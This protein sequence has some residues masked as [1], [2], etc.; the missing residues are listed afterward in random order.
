MKRTVSILFLLL[1]LILPTTA[2][3][4]KGNETFDSFNR[5]KRSLQHQ[6]YH[7]HR[8]TFYCGCPFD[9]SKKL[10]TSPHYTPKRVNSRSKRI[11]W[12]HVV[13]AYDFGR[14]FS[15]WRD[16]HPECV[17]SKGK[18]FKGRNCA[19]KMAIPFRYMEADLY[20]LVPAVGEINGLRSNYR[21]G[22]VPGEPREFGAC[23]FEIEDRM[24]EPADGVRGN[25][26]RTYKYMNWAYGRGIIGRARAK[27]FHAWGQSDPVD[28]WE[29]ERARRIEA[30]Q[31]NE[32]PF[33]KRACRSAGLW[34]G[35]IAPAP[36]AEDAYH[37]NVRSHVFHGPGCR[38][39][40]CKNCTVVFSTK[41]E[42][43]EA[44]YRAHEAC[45][46]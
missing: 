1:A 39:F 13:P 8:T 46:E 7:D 10:I 2:L 3:A 15:E 14:S 12:E 22:M 30:I 34:G 33:V 36:V 35:D 26:A 31:G 27:L 45:V 29:C 5:A 23:D 44:G 18:P 4:G 37:G 9:E 21:F 43:I 16:G 25:I 32:N 19:R 20:N 40:D 11:E 28:A 24:A 6:I 41:E 38:Y 42:A 17:D